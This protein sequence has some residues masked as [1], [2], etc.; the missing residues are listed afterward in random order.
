MLGLDKSWGRLEIKRGDNLATRLITEHAGEAATSWLKTAAGK[1]LTNEFKLT[2][3]Q[4]KELQANIR[5]QFKE[6][7][8]RHIYNT[9]ALAAQTMAEAAAKK[10]LDELADEFDVPKG[11]LNYDFKRN[12]Y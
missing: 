3:K 10:C 6:Q 12:R 9:A 2:E 8:E 11:S 5:R 7:V 1:A 4:E